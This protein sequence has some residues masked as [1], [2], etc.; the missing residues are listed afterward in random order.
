VKRRTIGIGHAVALLLAGALTLT[1]CA[2]ATADHSGAAGT[3]AGP[4]ESSMATAGPSESGMAAA[5]PPS[6]AAQMICGDDIRGQVQQ[7]LKLPT[8]P[9]TEHSWDGQLYTCNYRL[10]MG[11]M[12]LSVRQSAGKVAAA[13]YFT[14]LRSTFGST[15]T[16]QGLGERSYGTGAG[17]VVVIK[18]DL[19]LT[20]DTTGLPAVF[21]PDGQRRADLAYE[22]ASDVLGCWTGD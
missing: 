17:V 18:D 14:S 11:P 2:S 6:A 16:L 13:G 3:P 1:G 12:V 7:V 5:I 9:S 4:S 20:V 15:Q 21:G 22:I 8:L 19:T 10:P